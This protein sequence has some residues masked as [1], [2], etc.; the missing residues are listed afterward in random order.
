MRKA[1]IK[2]KNKIVKEGIICLIGGIFIANWY[3]IDIKDVNSPW[4][5]NKI[6]Y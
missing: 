5:E 6:K 2:Q 4:I 1:R 3:S